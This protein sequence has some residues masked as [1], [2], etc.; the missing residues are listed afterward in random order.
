MMDIYVSSC[1]VMDDLKSRVVVQGGAYIY[2]FTCSI[3]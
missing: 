2:L 1:N 3:F